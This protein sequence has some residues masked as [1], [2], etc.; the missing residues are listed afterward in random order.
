MLLL[1]LFSTSCFAQVSTAPLKELT[2]KE[3]TFTYVS[4][5]T[6]RLAYFGRGGEVTAS[7]F[8]N[9][10][11]GFQVEADYL[12]TNYANLRDMEVRGGTVV[13]LWTRNSVH[14]YV[15]V[16]IGYAFVKSSH[17]KPEAS[18]HDAPSV[19]AG[20]GLD[21]SVARAWHVKA[22]VDIENDWKTVATRVGRCVMGVSYRFGT[23]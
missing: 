12:R 7:N 4:G 21:V 14:P 9:K 3:L 10:N 17:L 22:G 8:L 1:L 18:F 5:E 20:G 13:R 11:V 16:L 19:L 23:R 15:H 6:N 2:S